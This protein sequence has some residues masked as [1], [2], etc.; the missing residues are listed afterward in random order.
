[1]L[2]FKFTPT[3]SMLTSPSYVLWTFT[4]RLQ[5]PTNSWLWLISEDKCIK[6]KQI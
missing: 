6:N 4:S 2:N 3:Q 5:S 1:V